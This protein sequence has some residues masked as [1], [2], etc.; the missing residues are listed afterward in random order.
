M[1]VTC[2]AVLSSMPNTT[3]KV[4]GGGEETPLAHSPVKQ[5]EIMQEVPDV[6][7]VSTHLTIKLNEDYCRFPKYSQR[8]V[9]S[10]PQRSIC[11]LHISGFVQ[12]DG[13]VVSWF[14]STPPLDADLGQLHG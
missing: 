11:G 10:V 9:L 1:V 12:D 14:E 8:D 3:K 6:C 7:Y 13:G 4:R 2:I 5:Q